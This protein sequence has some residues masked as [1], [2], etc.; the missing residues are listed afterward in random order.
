MPVRDARMTKSSTLVRSGIVL[1]YSKDV[2]TDPIPALPTT[3]RE[4]A[5]FVDRDW[6]LLIGGGLTAATQGEELAVINPATGEE[7]GRAP[8]A[9]PGD[10]DRAVAAAQAAFKDW[11]R[12]PAADR[13]RLVRELA[14]LIEAHAEELAVI[15]TADNGTPL[16]VMRGDANLA[17]GQLR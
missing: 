7:V 8:S 12:R 9:Q 13:A 1:L 4:A 6:R 10:V 14:D 11:G 17:V 5:A 15:D 3:S 16:R 2:L